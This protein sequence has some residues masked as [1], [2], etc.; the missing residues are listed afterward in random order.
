MRLYNFQYYLTFFF[1]NSKYL[2]DNI[3]KNSMNMNL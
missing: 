3:F 2:T 1:F